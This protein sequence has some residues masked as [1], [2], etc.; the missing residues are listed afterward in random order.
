MNKIKLA[1]LMGGIGCEREVSLVSGRG[2]VENLDKEKYEV[3]AVDVPR[4]LEKVVGCDVAFLALHG[5]GGEDGT[6]QG[7]LETLGI[8]YTGCGVLASAIGM[9]KVYFKWVMRE[10][11]IEVPKDGKGLPC[12]V[13][14]VRGGSSVGVSIVKKIEDLKKAK[15]LALQY[16]ELMIEEYIEGIE[17][18]CGVLGNPSAGSGQVTVLPIV[19]IRPKN[20]FFDYEAKYTDGKC[21]EICPAEIDEKVAKLVQKL[22]VEVFKLIGGRGY[23][24]IDFIIRNNI[25][26]LLE[27]NTLP[28]MTPN[29]LLPK[30]A[31]AI[32]INYPELLDKMVEL[33]REE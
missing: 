5:R 31:R 29:S 26:Y 27:I 4:E 6:I 20:E 23:A 32:G 8:K 19:E 16:G 7:Y 17:V 13:K 1:V 12:V 14:P 28:G 24:R 22:S 33:A 21:E 15:D 9:D 3:W 30:E 18:S 25:P 11:G 10:N 2:V